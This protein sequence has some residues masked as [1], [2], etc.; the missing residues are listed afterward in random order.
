VVND[1]VMMLPTAE[2]ESIVE[3]PERRKNRRFPLR[4]SATLRYGD[5][6][7][8]EL[9]AQTLN[10]SLKGMLLSLDQMV[11]DGA[12]VE[13]TL[14]LQKEGVESVA[15]HGT[16]KVVRQESR[17]AGQSAVAVAFQGQLH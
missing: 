1:Q 12:Q 6:G 8:R 10:A 11:P 9:K 4:Q 14:L 15:L 3:Q 13:V 7:V 16:G 17:S 5:G 2:P